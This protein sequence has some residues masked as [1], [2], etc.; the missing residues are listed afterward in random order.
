MG[1]EPNSVALDNVVAIEEEAGHI[2]HAHTL[3]AG[4]AQDAP[5]PQ[6]RA[7]GF[8]DDGL[9]VVRLKPCPDE[10]DLAGWAVLNTAIGVSLV[11]KTWFM[12]SLAASVFVSLSLSYFVFAKQ[13]DGRRGTWIKHSVPGLWI[14]NILASMVWFLALHRVH[15]P[16]LKRLLRSNPFEPCVLFS[17]MLF[18]QYA[19]CYDLSYSAGDS[20]PTASNTLR[21][22]W[23]VQ[24]ASFLALVDPIR[25]SRRFKKFV[26][27][28]CMLYIAYE[29]FLIL[30]SSERRWNTSLETMHGL[31]PWFM[32]NSP[33]QHYLS[34][35]LAVLT[36]LAKACNAFWFSDQ[37]FVHITFPARQVVETDE[38]AIN[39][40]RS[41]RL[42][43][44]SLSVFGFARRRTS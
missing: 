14:T 37:D 21:M 19:R 31:S 1:Q 41:T 4:E 40:V 27:T 22:W 13:Q 44:G 3:D 9:L 35:Q 24:G 32:A 8:L 6:R 23:V 12:I 42:A 2:G 26:Y 38:D 36:F 28:I 34:A 17:A 18:G 33:R 43:S 20:G 30:T 15:M 39:M 16:T 29:V 25:A 7:S 10:F 11:R 5:T